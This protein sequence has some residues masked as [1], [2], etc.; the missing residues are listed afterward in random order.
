VS[1]TA[2]PQR[3]EESVVVFAAS[4]AAGPSIAR[5]KAR[6][7]HFDFDE[8]P[9]SPS[10]DSQEVVTPGG[11]LAL[12]LGAHVGSRLIVGGALTI[13]VGVLPDRFTGERE[14][15]AALGIG[16]ELALVPNRDGGVFAFARGGVGIDNALVWSAAAGAGYAFPLGTTTLLGLGLQLSGSYSR[17][18]EDGDFGRY[19]YKDEIL[20]PAIMARLML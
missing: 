17:F 14:S 3:G 11:A 5:A 9:L 4:L 7:D 13:G 15:Y 10:F 20:A 2:Q 6:Y 12:T 19:T 1:P 8:G 18:G 16:P